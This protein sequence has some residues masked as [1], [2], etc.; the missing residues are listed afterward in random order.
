MAPPRQAVAL[1]DGHTWQFGFNCRTAASRLRQLITHDFRTIDR[2]V[3]P[4]LGIDPET[5]KRRGNQ[6]RPGAGKERVGVS[7]GRQINR[8]LAMELLVAT[9]LTCLDKPREVKSWCSVSAQGDPYFYAPGPHADIV[10]TYGEFRIVAE[11]SAARAAGNTGYFREQLNGAIRHALAATVGP[12]AGRTYALVIT[13]HSVATNLRMRAEYVAAVR[14]LDGMLRKV[15]AR[16]RRQ[17]RAG[18]EPDVRLVPVK[19]DVFTRVCREI[20]STAG[21][22]GAG[23]EITGATLARALDEV[24]RG[25]QEKRDIGQNDWLGS[26]LLT[27]LQSPAEERLAIEN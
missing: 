21:G 2:R 16:H 23:L 18:P 8:A 9:L 22:S 15:I 17:K 4:A 20:F 12:G 26:T 24:Y 25:L 10:A 19:S 13:C 11:V 5:R 7:D 14:R 1:R 27:A 3:L 6:L